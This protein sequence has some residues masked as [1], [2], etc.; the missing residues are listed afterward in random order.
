[1]KSSWSSLPIAALG[2]V[3]IAAF[4][5]CSGAETSTIDPASE[6]SGH[7]AVAHY[8]MHVQP[9]LRKATLHRLSAKAVALLDARGP[10]MLPQ[11]VTDAVLTQDD[12]QGSNNGSTTNNTVELVTGNVYDLDAANCGT[13]ASFCAD[14]TLN[15][16]WTKT[17]NFTYA[18]VT[19]ITDSS[20]QPLSGHGPISSGSYTT[21]TAPSG[22]SSGLGGWLHT[23]DS[24][25]A[26]QFAGSKTGAMLPWGYN[27][28]GSAN[29][30]TRRWVFANPDDAD[31]YIQLKV[32]GTTTYTN[33]GLATA[34]NAA[35]DGCTLNSG[36]NALN[37]TLNGVIKFPQ[38]LHTNSTYQVAI[39][40]AF[41]HYGTTYAANNQ[42]SFNKWGNFTFGA[43]PDSTG[44]NT[45]LPSTSA[46]HPA[47]FPWWD[48]NVWPSSIPTG[49]AGLCAKVTGTAP[50]RKA[51]LTWKKIGTNGAKGPFMTVH[52]AL[53]EGSDQIWFNY[54][55]QITGTGPAWSSAVGT[56]NEAGTVGVSQSFSA[57][58][59]ATSYVLTPKP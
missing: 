36:D 16:F 1:M 53:L 40:F 50:N 48:A 13:A 2:T 59:S 57:F 21:D 20:G 45:T 10:G 34:S 54:T 11:A 15:S 27:G 56:Q 24:L 51:I 25:N 29:G 33:Y 23:S 8:V 30:G 7:Q 49:T 9:K 18:Q 19:A 31:T 46:P 58:P 4:A 28:G 5:G 26:S 39:P 22:A 6:A 52:A 55:N 44:T 43:T 3:G 17:L 47:V 12:V 14:V 38:P 32:W 41:T 35:D 42:V 37:M